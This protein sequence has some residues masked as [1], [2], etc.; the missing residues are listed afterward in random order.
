MQNHRWRFVALTLF[1]TLLPATTNLGQATP[2]A[3]VKHFAVEFRTGPAWDPAKP[4]GEQPHFAEHSAN[5][6]KL[7]QEGRIVLG[8]RYGEVGLVV[9]AAASEDEVRAMIDADPS[10]QAGTF[11]YQLHP[12]SVFYPGCV[13][14][15]T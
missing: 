8:A 5:L 6:K 3:A 1:V 11:T 13:E 7:R 15:K 4:P 2:E 12:M 10:V 14:P 9:I